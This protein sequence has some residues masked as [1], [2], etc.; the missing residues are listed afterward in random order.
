M[1]FTPYLAGGKYVLGGYVA[2]RGL[3]G[4]AMA[5]R[6]VADPAGV[7]HGRQVHRGVHAAASI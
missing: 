4:K 7:G 5:A 2:T 6:A 3:K 1:E